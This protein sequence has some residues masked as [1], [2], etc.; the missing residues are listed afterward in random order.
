MRRAEREFND[1]Y[2]RR[3]RGSDCPKSLMAVILGRMA[4][5]KSIRGSDDAVYVRLA[6]EYNDLIGDKGPQILLNATAPSGVPENDE[7]GQVILPGRGYDNRLAVYRLVRSASTYLYWYER[8]M[9]RKVLEIL[10][11][12][13]QPSVDVRLLSGRVKVDQLPQLRQD[14][15]AFRK[16]MEA[17]QCRVQWRVWDEARPPHG[18]F[19]M[20]DSG[21]WNVPPLNTILKGDLDEILPSTQGPSD[22][23]ELWVKGIDLIDCLAEGK[24]TY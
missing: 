11:A 2:A 14:F 24:G 7:R 3:H 19:I 18:R 22:F 12:E 16:Q 13:L 4:Y 1:R 5:L 9:E 6:R 10:S 23:E 8:H 20:T 21:A 15:K 17:R